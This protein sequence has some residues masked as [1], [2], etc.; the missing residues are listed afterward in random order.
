MSKFEGHVGKEA[1]TG[2]PV[3]HKHRAAKTMKAKADT[4]PPSTDPRKT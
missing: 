4:Q 2:K 3:F 1:S